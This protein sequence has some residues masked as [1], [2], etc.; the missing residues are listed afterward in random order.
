MINIITNFQHQQ[1]KKRSEVLFE[2][3]NLISQ[4]GESLHYTELVSG[5]VL[6]SYH[7]DELL[8]VMILMYLV[9]GQWKDIVFL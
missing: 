5:S 1:E 8:I 6:K 3:E 2:T 4:S 7:I 9:I